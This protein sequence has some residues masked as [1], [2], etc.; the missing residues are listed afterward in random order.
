MKIAF[1]SALKLDT[2]ID[3]IVEYFSKK[4][5]VRKVITNF[6]N[7]IHNAVDYADTVF[8]E[9]C[10]ETAISGIN[11]L[12]DKNKRIIIRLHSYELFRDLIHRINWNLVD[13]L[14]FVAPH[15]KKIFLENVKLNKT[16]T[17]IIYNGIDFNKF[18]PVEGKI[19]GKKVAYVGSMSHKKN[20]PLLLYCMEKITM[21]DCDYTLHIAG[22]I[23]E[24]RLELYVRDMIQKMKLEV[25]FY[26]WVEDI[27]KWCSDKDY[28][29]NTSLF[30]GHNYGIMEGIASGLLPLIHHFYGAEGLYPENTLFTTPDKCLAILK[31]Y[32]CCDNSDKNRISLKYRESI[33]RFSLNNQL[34]KLDKLIGIG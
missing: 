18:K 26:D 5:E 11:H 25:V 14:I 2:F 24:S 1:I 23:Y 8:F 30:E 20:I 13:D 33:Q 12:K 21:F 16:R 34:E 19:Y 32:H 28:I 6:E 27:P 15:T 4:Y 22:E 17:H 3:D 31:R 29:I 7:E 9:F 10:N